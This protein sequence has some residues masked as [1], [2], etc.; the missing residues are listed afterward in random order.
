MWLDQ[1][2]DEILFYGGMVTA[3]IAVLL[4]IAY[5]VIYLI[6]RRRLNQKFDSEYGP[7]TRRK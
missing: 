7:A 1:I 2:P 4:G 3:G 6:G 5:L